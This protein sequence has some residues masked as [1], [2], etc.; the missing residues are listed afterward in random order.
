MIFLV[1]WRHIDVSTPIN[2]TFMDFDKPNIERR[3]N[4]RHKRYSEIWNRLENTELIDDGEFTEEYPKHDFLKWAVE[5]KN[6]LL[7]GSNN[8]NISH[9]EPRLANCTSKEFG[10]KEGVYATE[11]EILPMFYSIKDREKFKGVARSGTTTRY[12]NG[13]INKEYSFAVTA[14]TLKNTPWST[15]VVYLLPRD[16]FIQGTNDNGD[17]IDEWMSE[18][19]IKPLAKLVVSPSDFPYLDKIQ[20][21]S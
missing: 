3:E 21:I 1:Y 11:D 17:L 12:D 7:H 8:D 20:P 18:Q 13:Q 5:E 16:T 14:Q 15:G 6:V 2:S 10:N 4:M 19:S 9:L